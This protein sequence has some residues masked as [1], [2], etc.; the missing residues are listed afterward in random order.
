M[1]R[2]GDT[3]HVIFKGVLILHNHKR[4]L[5]KIQRLFAYKFAAS[6]ADASVGSDGSETFAAASGAGSAA[7]SERG[8]GSSMAA[9][10]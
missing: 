3:V 2:N 8:S 1:P 6:G 9:G 7:D 5:V 10:A 4:G